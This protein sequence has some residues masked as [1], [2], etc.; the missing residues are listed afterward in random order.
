MPAKLHLE[1][2]TV[3]HLSIICR[4]DAPCLSS[5]TA[6]LPHWLCRCDCGVVEII[7]QYRL[8][9]NHRRV[10]ACA[11]CMG[12]A[13]IV[14]GTTIPRDVASVTCSDACKIEHKR[15]QQRRHYY[16]RRRDD[17]QY[18]KLRAE[19]KQTMDLRMSDAEK[20]ISYTNKYQRLLKQFSRDEINRR[21]REYH[22]LRMSDPEYRAKRQQVADER[23]LKNIEKY[24]EY[25]RNYRRRKRAIL[26]AQEIGNFAE[27]NKNDN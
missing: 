15:E 4:A 22:A 7:P 11:M 14:C 23:K 6:S 1:G 25:Y 10:T 19:Y 2:G 21:A 27:D 18:K 20:K 5:S 12:H 16:L 13:C 26:A 3:G 17:P 9:T 8:T 24:R